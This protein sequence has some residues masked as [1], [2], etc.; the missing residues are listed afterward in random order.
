MFPHPP[1]LFSPTQVPNTVPYTH[2]LCLFIPM[3]PHPPALFSS[4]QV[5]NTV[6]NTHTPYVYSSLCFLTPL[7]SFPHRRCLTPS[8]IH[9]HPIF[10]PMLTHPPA[11]FSPTQ[12]PNTVKA[13]LDEV[14]SSLAHRFKETS[15][16]HLLERLVQCAA[17]TPAAG[18]M[19]PG[20]PR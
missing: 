11:L 9:T 20:M 3:L 10:I 18:P 19:L 12:V 14:L 2:T 15:G 7:L 13:S 5:P 16:V 17:V 1:A 4:T 6:P 8:P